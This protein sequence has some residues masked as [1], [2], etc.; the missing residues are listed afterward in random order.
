[1]WRKWRAWEMHLNRSCAVKLVQCTLWCSLSLRASKHLIFIVC[2]PFLKRSNSSQ[3]VWKEKQNYLCERLSGRFS[4]AICF[5]DS[6]TRHFFPFSILLIWPRKREL[7][8]IR[9]DGWHISTHTMKMT[10]CPC[11][12]K[13]EVLS[14]LI[15]DTLS[16]VGFDSACE[17]LEARA[18][19]RV[20][21][22][23]VRVW[24]Q[25]AFI[26]KVM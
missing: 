20:L 23:T 6:P 9:W 14:C 16:P 26:N 7:K 13:P 25:S 22:Y 4:A 5:L 11:R 21:I 12:N 1:M 15:R 8:L 24:Y 10:D 18:D 19:G 3:G 2:M 17:S